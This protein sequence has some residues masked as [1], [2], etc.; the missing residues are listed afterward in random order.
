MSRGYRRFLP[1][2]IARKLLVALLAS[3]VLYTLLMLVLF[4]SRGDERA[5]LHGERQ[6]SR[7]HWASDL[8][9]ARLTEVHLA[10]GRSLVTVVCILSAYWHASELRVHR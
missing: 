7:V 4:G 8:R 6:A 9:N 2:A 3:I 10:F 1:T 5:L